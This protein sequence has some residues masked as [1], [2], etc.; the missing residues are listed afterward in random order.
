V[1]GVTDALLAQ[2]APAAQGDAILLVQISGSPQ[3][4]GDSGPPSAAAMGGRG[5]AGL[6][7]GAFGGGAQQIGPAPSGADSGFQIYAVFVSVADKRSVAEIRMS[8]GGKRVDDA[9][10]QFNQRAALE[11]PGTKCRGWNWAGHIDPAAIK[12]LS[13]VSESAAAR[14]PEN[15][16]DLSPPGTTQ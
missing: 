13:V 3:H 8:Y 16:N 6:Q 15:K 12:N 10:E 1:N 5:R 7:G 2:L 14:P 11:F 9:L 4:S